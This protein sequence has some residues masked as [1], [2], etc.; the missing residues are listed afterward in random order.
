MFIAATAEKMWLSRESMSRS[1]PSPPP[2]SERAPSD[3][4]QYSA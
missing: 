1:K 3:R 4:R 2:F